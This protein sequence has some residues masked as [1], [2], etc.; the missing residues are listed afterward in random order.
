MSSIAKIDLFTYLTRTNT[1]RHKELRTFYSCLAKALEILHKQKVRH[2]NIKPSN[3]LVYYKKIL[4]TDFKLS[5][6]FTNTKG[7]TTVSIVNRITLRY[8]AL[9]VVMYKP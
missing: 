3:I 7:S 8:C 4:F 5:F 9:K 2:K 6:D 1:S